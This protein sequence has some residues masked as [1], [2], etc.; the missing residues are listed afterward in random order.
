[1]YSATNRG[2]KGQ[3]MTDVEQ[4]VRNRLNRNERVFYAV[5]PL[6]YSGN[7][8]RSLVPFGFNVTINSASGYKNYNVGNF[9]N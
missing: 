3:S 5:I 1:M 2:G 4:D 6:Y 9:P 8:G 7:G